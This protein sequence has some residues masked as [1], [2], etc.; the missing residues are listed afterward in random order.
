MVGIWLMPWILHFVAYALDFI[1]KNDPAVMT[2]RNQENHPVAFTG[3][4]LIICQLLACG[5]AQSM[6]MRGP[7]TTDAFLFLEACSFTKELFPE[8]V[9]P[10]NHAAPYCDPNTGKEAPFITMGPFSSTGHAFPWVLPG[11]LELY[12]TEEVMHLRSTGALKSSSGASL[13]LSQVVIACIS[14]PNTICPH[15]SQDN[16]W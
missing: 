13:S 2:F 15:H 12:T 7:P 4:G 5:T 3:D 8:I 10:Q 6:S 11:D 16:S 14:G 9:I 1:D